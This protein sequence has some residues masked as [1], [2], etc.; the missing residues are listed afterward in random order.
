[1]AE[2]KTVHETALLQDYSFW[3][4]IRKLKLYYYFGTSGLSVILVLFLLMTMCFQK[5][6]FNLCNKILTIIIYILAMLGFCFDLIQIY[7][8]I[9]NFY[10]YQ[11]LDSKNC[12]DQ[13]VNSVIYGLHKDFYFLNLCL[14]IFLVILIFMLIF[15]LRFWKSFGDYRDD[16]KFS[17]SNFNLGL[18]F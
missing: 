5:I 18:V 10:R 1:M 13:I 9:T 6:Y 16:E 17:D 15:S 7:L 12:G 14:V 8:S 4:Q 3:F 11:N 2:Y